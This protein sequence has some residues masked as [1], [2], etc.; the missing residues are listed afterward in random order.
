MIILYTGVV[1]GQTLQDRL[2]SLDG[3]I[4]AA[5]RSAAT[6]SLREGATALLVRS[7]GDYLWIAVHS[8]SIGV[9]SLCLGASESV[10]VLHA[11]AAL[12][13]VT[14]DRRGSDWTT[15][16]EFTWA[17]RDT[18]M[19]PA[20]IGE[21][22]AYLSENGWVATTSR[23]GHP[24]H[25]EFLIR[26]G[27]LPEGD[28]YLALGIMPLQHPDTIAGYPMASAGDCARD[29]LVRGQVPESGL[30]F[31]PESWQKIVQGVQ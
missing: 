1:Q 16:Q 22:Q 15:D 3:V 21:R 8:D 12:G 10:Q 14:Y 29:D 13:R 6:D 17:L 30:R 20:A 4:T 25:T 9:A 18:S 7:E 24:D 27:G 5:D 23:M 19:T 28:L 31:D 11:S 26:R 2:L